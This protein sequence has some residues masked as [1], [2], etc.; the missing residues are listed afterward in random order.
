ME[1]NLAAELLLRLRARTIERTQLAI[2]LPLAANLLTIVVVILA[3]HFAPERMAILLSLCSI[4]SCACALVAMR[5]VERTI[6]YG[7]GDAMLAHGLQARVVTFTVIEWESP[8][9]EWRIIGE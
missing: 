7:I 2:L 8:T 3:L 6:D 5:S 4:V 9:M 1:L